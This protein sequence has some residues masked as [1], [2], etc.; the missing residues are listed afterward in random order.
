VAKL[1]C[2]AGVIFRAFG[3]PDAVAVGQALA[4]LCRRRG[5]T[6]LVGADE[7]LAAQVGADGVH[8]P[9]RDLSV[10]RRLRMRRP[11][12]I[13]TGAAHSRAA[14]ARADRSG[15]DAVLLS[16]L[17]ESRSPSAGR[18]LGLLR[19]QAMTR[20]ARTPV[21]ALGGVNA[22]TARRL[23]LSRAQGIAAVEALVD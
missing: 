2:G 12:W 21:Y 19:F 4:G 13:L 7:G 5:L 10:A 14:L 23:Q 8:L 16:P 3:R 1:P 15:V 18:P 11:R 6:L 20:G 22:S 17:F 9:E